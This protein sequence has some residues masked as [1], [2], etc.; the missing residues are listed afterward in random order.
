[1]KKTIKQKYKDILLIIFFFVW[2]FNV[3]VE[4]E[5]VSVTANIIAIVLISLISFI[6]YYTKDD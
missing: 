2:V 4:N 5:R 1:M 6:K 3:F